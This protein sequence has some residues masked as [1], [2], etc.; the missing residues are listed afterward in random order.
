MKYF[1]PELLALCRSPDEDVA[2]AAAAKWEQAIA[3]YNARLREIRPAL[4]LGARRLLRHASLHDAQWLTLKT[5]AGS[6]GKEL[7]L[8][9]RLA[10]SPGKPTG[11]VELCYLLTGRST[12]SLDKGRDAAAGIAPPFVLYDEFDLEQRRDTRTFTHSLLL[13]NGQ[14]FRIRFSN[15]RLRWFGSVLLANSR[16]AEIKREWAD[17]DQLATT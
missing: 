7:F 9:F 4:P 11:G 1:T 5:V 10:G 16:P 3:A 15:L 2:E 14:E 17:D 13:S 6:A 8:T 12:L